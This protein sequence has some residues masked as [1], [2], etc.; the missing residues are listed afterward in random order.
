VNMPNAISKYLDAAQAKGYVQHDNPEFS[1]DRPHME[2]AVSHDS[3]FVMDPQGSKIPLKEILESG[4]LIRG[5]Y[6]SNAGLILGQHIARHTR[7]RFPERVIR[8]FT[9]TVEEDFNTLQQVTGYIRD[10]LGPYIAQSD[11]DKLRLDSSSDNYDLFAVGARAKYML[12]EVAEQGEAEADMENIRR[13]RKMV[14]GVVDNFYKGVH[15]ARVNHRLRYDSGYMLAH[16]VSLSRGAGVYLGTKSDVDP[17]TR[18]NV[19][20]NC[21]PV[22]KALNLNKELERGQWLQVKSGQPFKATEGVMAELFMRDGQVSSRVF[23]TDIEELTFAPNAIVEDPRKQIVGPNGKVEDGFRQWTMRAGKLFVYAREFVDNRAQSNKLIK[24]DQ[25]N[26][27]RVMRG[28][29]TVAAQGA[30]PITLEAGSSIIKFPG[31]EL[32]VNPTDVFPS[33]WAVS[34]LRVIK[35][36]GIVTRGP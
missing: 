29:V 2:D 10:T 19:C 3:S 33:T 11:L 27:V 9:G 7:G 28:R 26:H 20:Y 16:I 24:R 12:E 21:S 1:L 18:K 31:A 15:I 34:T 8:V 30:E 5:L 35:K 22:E 36:P 32:M 14:V 23:G 6:P 13:W 17:E 4:D 25:Y